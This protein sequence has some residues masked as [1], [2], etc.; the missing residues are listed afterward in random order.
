[1]VHLARFVGKMPSSANLHALSYDV[2][3][4]AVTRV[5]AVRIQ[6]FRRNSLACGSGISPFL[7]AHGVTEGSE[8][9][10]NQ[11][12]VLGLVGNIFV[13]VQ[14]VHGL[15]RTYEPIDRSQWADQ[16]SFVV[17]FGGNVLVRLETELIL[18]LSK[19]VV[20]V[21]NTHTQA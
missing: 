10:E 11:H 20:R 19:H 13:V 15:V 21:D 7:L 9:V 18:Q 2:S 1:M 3:A 17:S 8:L 4:S 5:G 12:V 14:P 16:F 6:C